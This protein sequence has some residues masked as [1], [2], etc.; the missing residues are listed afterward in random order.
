MSTPEPRI[1]GYRV[2]GVQ[3]R[4]PAPRRRARVRWPTGVGTTRCDPALV[5]LFADSGPAG[6]AESDPRADRLVEQLGA[7]VLAVSAAHT[8]EAQATVAWAADPAAALGADP[9]RIVV[10]G[11]GAGAAAAARVADLAVD[12]GWPPLHR[13]VLVWPHDDPAAALGELARALTETARP[14]LRRAQ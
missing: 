11:P 7:V 13:V 1:R 9:R 4:P 5:V 12:E 6:S 8:I 2:A 14:P 3:L 10:V